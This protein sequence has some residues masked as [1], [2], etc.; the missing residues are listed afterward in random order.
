MSEA[1]I[2]TASKLYKCRN[3]AKFLAGDEYPA[4]IDSYKQAIRWYMK[5]HNCDEL[6][7]AINLA[8]A[9]KGAKGESAATMWLMAAAVELIEPENTKS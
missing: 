5:K 9:V 1:L 8:K 2:N 7:A 4:K 6:H 3:A